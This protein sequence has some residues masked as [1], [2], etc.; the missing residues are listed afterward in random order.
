MENAVGGKCRVQDIQFLLRSS[1]SQTLRVYRERIL[2]L[3]SFFS[4]NAP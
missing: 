2:S 4:S 1:E 3:G